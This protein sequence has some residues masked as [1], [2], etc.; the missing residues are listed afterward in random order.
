M[1]IAMCVPPPY[2]ASLVVASLRPNGILWML[3]WNSSASPVLAVLL[4]SIP[5][6]IRPVDRLSIRMSRHKVR[7]PYLN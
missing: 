2:T 3:L 7:Q 6:R 5:K 1:A 4:K